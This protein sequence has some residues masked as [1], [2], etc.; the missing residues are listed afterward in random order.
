VTFAQNVKKL[1]IDPPYCIYGKIN[2]KLKHALK[3][4]TCFTD[5]ILRHLLFNDSRTHFSETVRDDWFW[6]HVK[7]HQNMSHF[8]P[9]LSGPAL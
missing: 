5:A 6:R 4:L 1:K 7:N 2:V 8:G 9:D 3:N